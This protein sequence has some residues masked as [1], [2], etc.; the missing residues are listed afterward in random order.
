MH[1]GTLVS[2]PKKVCNI[3]NQYFVDK[4]TKLKMRTNLD[5]DKS[6][7]IMDKYLKW[8][9]SNVSKFQFTPVHQWQVMKVIESLNNTHSVGDDQVSAIV[10]KNCKNVLVNPLTHIINL[11]LTQGYYPRAWKKGL[12]VPIEK[13]GDMTMP[14]NWRPVCK[15]SCLSK[16]LEKIMQNQIN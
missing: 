5:I 14:N 10:I 2:D 7:E 3:M 4:I 6:A 12:V 1:N 16:V 13:S 8:D 11:C 9:R 15:Q